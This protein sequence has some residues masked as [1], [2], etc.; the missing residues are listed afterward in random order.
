MNL[1]IYTT[2][3]PTTKEEEVLRRRMY[4]FLNSYYGGALSPQWS[5]EKMLETGYGFLEVYK[6]LSNILNYV[7]LPPKAKI[8]DSGCGFGYFVAYCLEHNFDIYGYEVDNKL[9]QIA[10]D[11]LSLHNFNSNRI[12][13][14]DGKR[15]PYKDNGFDFINMHF[16]V[17]FISDLPKTMK[18]L[19]RILKPK[20]KIF[21]ITPNYLCCFSPALAILF[22]PWAP[23]FINRLYLKLKGR[24]NTKPFDN[25]YFVSPF[26]LKKI[27]KNIGFQIK[28]WGKKDWIE[29]PRKSRFDN[30]SNV[31]RY[32]G[33]KMPWLFSLTAW[34]GLYTPLVYEL[35]KQED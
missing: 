17:D 18:E 12:V 33:K 23:R 34:L 7:N 1:K 8:L 27:F 13:F 5:V 15:L 22:F 30:R 14:F 32:M 35:I 20:G 3:Q 28:N 4:Q 24:P 25:L 26:R 31:V 29:I 21:I 11:L 9:V 16:V 2:N 10:K 6:Q 19:Y